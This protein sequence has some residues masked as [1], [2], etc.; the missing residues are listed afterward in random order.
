MALLPYPDRDTLPTELAQML[1][2]MPRHAPI[3]MLAHS[4]Y[5]AQQF[6]RLAQAQ[7]TTLELS[8]YN[9]ELVI[10][11]VAAFVGCEYEYRQHIPISAA[12]GVDPNVRESIWS[13]S[14]GESQLAD[15][16]RAL[17]AFVGAALRSPRIGD[18]QLVDVREHF[19][20]REIVE[21]L[22][23]IGFYWGLGRLCTVLD[24]EVET[25][26]DLTSVNAVANLSGGR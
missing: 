13:S 8:L 20:D 7:F 14:V 19:S 17:V 16:D 6:L 24:L 25:A 22:Q 10:L 26:T 18:R 21:I 4:P 5:V 9:R 2:E 23:L 12:A 11:T 1:G 15:A 3:D